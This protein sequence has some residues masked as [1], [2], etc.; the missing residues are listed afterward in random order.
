MKFNY[1]KGYKNGGR[2]AVAIS[3][4]DFKEELNKLNNKCVISKFKT[5]KF[6][7]IGEDGLDDLAMEF[8][9]QC[10]D[11]RKIETYAENIDASGHDFGNPDVCGI[12]E[13]DNGLVYL[14]FCCGGDAEIPFYAIIYFD[15][16]KLRGYIPVNG[17]PWN[18]DL[19]CAFGSEEYT[20]ESE[21]YIEK[22]SKKGI[23]F[24]DSND[25]YAAYTKL[26]CELH[27]IKSEDGYYDD[28]DVDVDIFNEDIKHR[29]VIDGQTPGGSTGAA[30]HKTPAS[31]KSKS[32]AKPAAYEVFK[33]NGRS[34]VKFGKGFPVLSIEELQVHLNLGW[35]FRSF[36][37]VHEFV[38]ACLGKFVLVNPNGTVAGET[39]INDAFRLPLGCT[40]LGVFGGNVDSMKRCVYLYKPQDIKKK[41]DMSMYLSYDL[42]AFV[43]DGDDVY[44]VQHFFFI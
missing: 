30:P 38:E 2:T 10:D 12:H 7:E 4:E 28:V 26:F 24:D 20:G 31:S 33:K 14:G 40:P 15:G 41:G 25:C 3:V 1:I 21:W 42:A 17:N 27:G 19:K 16:K 32:A 9:A 36:S 37:S 22:A 11:F 39:D 43:A 13:L 44:Y 8:F 34:Y 6:E 5:K 29:I 35:L 23:E 18:S